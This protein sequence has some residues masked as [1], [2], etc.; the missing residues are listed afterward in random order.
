MV[1]SSALIITEEM[2][3]PPFSPKRQVELIQIARMY[4][5]E[6]DIPI[7]QNSL[8]SAMGVLGDAFLRQRKI[9]PADIYSG[10]HP[11]RPLIKEG[12]GLREE[13]K[14][15]AVTL[16]RITQQNPTNCKDPQGP[17]AIPGDVIK[18]AEGEASRF[19]LTGNLGGLEELVKVSEQRMVLT[20]GLAA[21]VLSS[22][23]VELSA[24]SVDSFPNP[25]DQAKI[26]R[27]SIVKFI[28]AHNL[29]PLFN[30][31][32]LKLYSSIA[33]TQ[34]IIFEEHIKSSLA[35][36]MNVTEQSELSYLY[37]L[38]EQVK[39][40]F[41]R[42]PEM[43]Y[44]DKISE[45][46]FF[47]SYYAHDLLLLHPVLEQ[48]KIVTHPAEIIEGNPHVWE[49]GVI[50]GDVIIP[51]PEMLLSAFRQERVILSEQRRVSVDE[52]GHFFRQDNSLRRLSAG[53]SC[54]RWL[55]LEEKQDQLRIRD[56]E[57]KIGV[58]EDE[59]TKISSLEI[60]LPDAAYRLHAVITSD[61]H[62]KLSGE[63]IHA[64]NITKRILRIASLIEQGRT[65][66]D[67]LLESYPGGLP[68]QV[69]M[70]AEAYFGKQRSTT[71]SLSYLERRLVGIGSLMEMEILTGLPKQEWSYDFISELGPDLVD[72]EI[73]RLNNLDSSLLSSFNFLSAY[74]RIDENLEVLTKTRWMQ[75][76]DG[77]KTYLIDLYSRLGLI[78]GSE[79]VEG[80]ANRF[81]QSLIHE[82]IARRKNILRKARKD[83]LK[84]GAALGTKSELDKSIPQGIVWRD[85]KWSS[86]EAIDYIR[87]LQA[88]DIGLMD[89]EEI[90]ELMLKDRADF[91]NWHQFPRR[92][93]PPTIP[94]YDTLLMDVTENLERARLDRGYTSAWAESEHN[95]EKKRFETLR[96]GLEE[97]CPPLPIGEGLRAEAFMHA[98]NRRLQTVWGIEDFAEIDQSTKILI[99]QHEVIARNAYRNVL[100]NRIRFLSYA[101]EK[102]KSRDLNS[103]LVEKMRSLDLVLETI[104]RLE[105]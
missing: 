42:Q 44:P 7:S 93:L 48:Q 36:N 31:D 41:F 55:A 30:I 97:Y 62:M 46:E 80:G 104:P 3:L 9:Q 53:V 65:Y 84:R 15:R 71:L 103:E 61:V 69:P 33:K 66:H 4:L 26:I 32:Q 77:Y 11:I 75:E 13:F 76:L 96:K 56:L 37:D 95:E 49:G 94:K 51:S 91:W 1:E 22:L 8:K 6:R 90:L 63:N 74:Q 38:F 10:K 70:P 73:R 24:A 52:E 16:L 29:S 88:S 19:D 101:V 64:A 45:S 60:P 100:E 17:F 72:N 50:I 86:E 23:P 85:Q 18:K 2:R 92:L 58:V 14:Q 43:T 82:A 21:K 89:S 81:K 105:I 20:R 35:R 25:S 12:V 54:W 87:E 83:I 78:V 5:R 99:E 68:K 39:T 98:W 59:C 40:S 102:V 27:N 47:H 79:K 57:R 67:W 28:F 34:P